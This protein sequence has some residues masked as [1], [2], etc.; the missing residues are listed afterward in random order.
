MS[1][2]AHMVVPRSTLCQTMASRALNRASVSCMRKGLQRNGSWHCRD[3]IPGIAE[4]LELQSCG[5]SKIQFLRVNF[6]KH[7]FC[8]KLMVFLLASAMLRCFSDVLPQKAPNM[9]LAMCPNI[10]F[11]APWVSDGYPYVSCETSKNVEMMAKTG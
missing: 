10:Q 4:E 6:I 8:G 9:F 5:I 2:V 3:V 1:H 7:K 11:E